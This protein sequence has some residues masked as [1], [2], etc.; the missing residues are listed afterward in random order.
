MEEPFMKKFIL[1]LLAIEMAV[2]FGCA[3]ST[4]LVK[5]AKLFEITNDDYSTVYM[6][7]ESRVYGSIKAY[8]MLI[9]GVFLF[10]IGSGDCVTFKIPTGE[11]GIDLFPTMKQVRFMS[12]KGK[13]YYF[14]VSSKG[15]E[16]RQ[17]TEEEW[18]EKQKACNWVDLKE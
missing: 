10:R 2:F 3:G 11:S 16:L 6:S 5:G 1:F 15:P 14:Y 12:E 17:L 4:K 9:N 7:R 18:N 8:T 13:K